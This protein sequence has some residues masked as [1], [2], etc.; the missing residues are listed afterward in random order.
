VKQFETGLLDCLVFE[1]GAMP[2][3]QVQVLKSQV[4]PETK[5]KEQFV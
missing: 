5:E 1:R 3:R 4:A 2:W